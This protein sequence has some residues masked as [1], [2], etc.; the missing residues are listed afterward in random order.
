LFGGYA[1]AGSKIIAKVNGAALT[2]L[3]LQDELDKL[4]PRSFFHG[5]SSEIKRTA[6]RPQALNNIIKN[7]LLFQEA[8]RM[9]LKVDNSLIND[10]RKSTMK[11]L[12]GKKAFKS[13]LKQKGITDKE[14]RKKLEKNFLVE[15]ILEKEVNQKSEV[16]DEE[17]A[18]YYEENKKTYVRPSSRRI[19]HVLIKV[20]PSSSS[21]Q[22]QD[23]KKWAEKALNM[24]KKED[25]DLYQI[26]WDYSDGPFRVKGG[27]LGLVHK[28]R[29]QP[30]VDE[31]AFNLENGQISGIIESLYG[32][33]IVKVTGIEDSKQLSLKDVSE[34]IKRELQEFK[35]KRTKDALIS[36]LREQAAIE[37]YEEG[38]EQ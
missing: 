33:H 6:L 9:R 32:Y 1:E 28:G 17:V 16:S 13:V 36:R 3:D 30:E 5:T 10:T 12:G 38:T 24:A 2:E 27:D 22:R 11:R 21:E 20:H 18:K 31:A 35:L 8:K 15:I 25:A 23:K 14:Y 7:E 34:K 19:W 37:V 29:L 26:A 4:Y